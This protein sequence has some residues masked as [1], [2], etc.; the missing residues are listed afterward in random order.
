MRRIRVLEEITDR[1]LPL[2]LRIRASRLARRAFRMSAEEL[3]RVLEL[4]GRSIVY[5]LK[6]HVAAVRI[7]EAGTIHVGELL[8]GKIYGEG[9][10]RIMDIDHARRLARGVIFHRIIW[11]YLSRQ[12]QCVPEL[13][14]SYFIG[15][16]MLVGTVDSLCYIEEFD[17]GSPVIYEFKSS[18]SD[19]SIA[20]GILQ[21]QIYSHI[22]W[23]QGIKVP[24]Y[25]VLS[26]RTVLCFRSSRSRARSILSAVLEGVYP[27][28]H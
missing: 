18:S 7:H 10:V 15:N 28:F 17:S 24:A 20:Y 27:S 5:P 22:A 12:A 25:C 11:R 3:A 13:Q 26:P 14:L 2:D 23:S 8:S 6:D 9:R 19:K 16:M 4:S 1:I 21:G